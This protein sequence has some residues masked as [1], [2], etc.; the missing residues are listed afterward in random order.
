MSFGEQRIQ[1]PGAA[2]SQQEVAAHAVSESQ[3]DGFYMKEIDYPPGFIVPRHW[4]TSAS[5]FLILRGGSTEVHGSSRWE[6]EPL[7]VVLMPRGETHAEH[8][9]KGAVRSFVFEIQPKWLTKLSEHSVALDSPKIFHGGPVSWIFMSLY[10]EYRRMDS[11]SVLA[12]ENL[13][14]EMAATIGSQE[15]KPQSQLPRWLSQTRDLLNDCFSSQLSLEAIAKSAGVH[16]VY[17]ATIF[18][19]HYGC[20]MGQYIRRLRVE[21]ACRELIKSRTSLVDIALAAGFSDQSHL[22]KIFKQFTGMS[23]SKFRKTY[24]P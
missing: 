24:T 17:L 8:M 11:V 14:L 23:P 2:L 1:F 15:V 4:H 22:S 5:L 6:C 7:D 16:P 9:A 3:I 19:R 10:Q 20:T 13:A 12:I 21:F 18:R